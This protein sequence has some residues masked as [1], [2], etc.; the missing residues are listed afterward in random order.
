MGRLV[1][2]PPELTSLSDDID[3][4]S[5]DS[6]PVASTTQD[7][8][9]AQFIVQEWLFLLLAVPPSGSFY[10]YLICVGACLHTCLCATGVPSTCRAQKK[11]WD[12]LELELQLSA[13]PCVCLE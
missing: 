12:L 7:D 13:S 4:P 3:S 9:F 6:F 2:L 8:L 10:L 1:F 11:V 5:F